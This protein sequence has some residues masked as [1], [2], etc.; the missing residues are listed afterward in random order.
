M[1]KRHVLCAAV[2]AAALTACGGGSDSSPAPSPG[3]AP[4]P[5]P[6]PAPIP[7]SGDR[8]EPLDTALLPRSAEVAKLA[9]AG[10]RLPAGTPVELVSLG[11]L[12]MLKTATA[13]KAGS[14]LKIGESREVPATA[15]PGDLATLLHWRPIAG[16]GQVAAVAFSAEGA[17]AI[18]LAVRA[19]EMPAGAVLRFYG[20]DDDVV[21]MTAD[22]VAELRR[23][24][25]AGGV[26]GG[27]ARTVWGP[28]TAGSVSTL[29]V[30]L[31]PGVDPATL[32][33]AVPR[34]SHLSMTAEQTWAPEKSVL[35][36]GDA[37]S[38]NLDVMCR[39]DLQAE[40]RSV[41][42]MIYS[43]RNGTFMCTGTLMN[44][45]ASSQTPYFLTASHCIASQSEASSLITYWFFHA[46][47]CNSSPQYDSSVMRIEGGAT[48][49]WSNAM[50]DTTLL[51]LNT[52]PPANV[53]YAGSYF[54]DGLVPGVE[55]TGIHHPAGDLQ[56]YS[57]GQVLDYAVCTGDICE[58]A[59]AGSGT[60]VRV[61]WQYGTTEQG[62]SGS[63]IFAS[64]GDTR[65]VVGTLWG[66]N[67]SCEARSGSDYYGRLEKS[68]EAGVRQWLMP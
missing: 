16:G 47:S 3:P 26:W 8:I 31:P 25:E 66:G 65:Y 48:F 51:R 33:L 1:I 41:A 18:R 19:D 44:D 57:M 37:E 15:E 50:I 35:S 12:T 6:A 63:A 67:A 38:C 34:L 11:P 4:A 23:A 5:S 53:V 40:S 7:A 32:Q 27:D 64:S 43:N 61:S 52:R 30:Q 24:N 20:A 46:A 42:K 54:G 14:A 17:K 13:S 62:S 2:A 55:V 60:R 56:K 28:D 39:P 36:I 10:K 68:F 29:E 59:N 58:G 22:R 21:E 9:V 49:L 45:A